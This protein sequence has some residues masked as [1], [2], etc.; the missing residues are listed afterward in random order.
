MEDH[1]T[2]VAGQIRGRQTGTFTSVAG[3][4]RGRQT[5]TFTSVAGQI[6]GRDRL[7]H[8]LG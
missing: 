8:S 2:R 7:A 6:R 1:S 4:I 5:G 3:Q